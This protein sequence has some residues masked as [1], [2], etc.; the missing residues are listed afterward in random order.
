MFEYAFVTDKGLKRSLN[1]DSIALDDK[2]VSASDRKKH[3]V[4]LKN[5]FRAAVFDGVGGEDCGEVAS[6]ICAQAFRR[7]CRPERI[8]D[9]NDVYNLVQCIQNELFKAQNAEGVEMMTT[10]VGVSCFK[11]QLVF[12][13][14]G[15]SRAYLFSDYRIKQYSYDDTYLNQLKKSSSVSKEDLENIDTA[16]VITHCFG[17]RGFDKN[18]C[19]S[20]ILERKKGDIAILMSDGI[21]DIVN[22]R[23]L[24][25]IILKNKK[26]QAIVDSVVKLVIERGAHD[27]YTLVVIKI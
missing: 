25:M 14:I 21:S 2:T 7:Y 11:D 18:H 13:N 1:E 3:R 17:M 22:E 19:H 6:S 20:Y 10:F 15:D 24:E 23:E 8:C 26:P 12:M 27:N 4:S 16:H 5:N 9:R